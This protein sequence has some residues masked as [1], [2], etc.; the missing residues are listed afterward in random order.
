MHLVRQSWHPGRVLSTWAEVFGYVFEHGQV[1]A[2][3][4]APRRTS[5]RSRM[6]RSFVPL[7]ER[8]FGELCFYIDAHDALLRNEAALLDAHSFGEVFDA[9]LDALDAWKTVRG[10]DPD[11]WSHRCGCCDQAQSCRMQ[12][13]TIKPAIAAMMNR[14]SQAPSATA[15]ALLG[16]SVAT[17]CHTRGRCWPKSCLS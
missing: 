16:R 1:K 15:V 10:A 8:Y 3:N 6:T 14:G 5:R 12:R 13:C 11:F 7:D 9:S 2:P 17:Q 4:A